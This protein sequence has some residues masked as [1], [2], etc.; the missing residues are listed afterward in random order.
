VAALRETSQTREKEIDRGAFCNIVFFSA[1]A[2]LPRPVHPTK[3]I[4]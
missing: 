3:T 4:T 1:K 2:A